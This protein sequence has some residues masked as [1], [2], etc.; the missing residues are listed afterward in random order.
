MFVVAL[1]ES[2]AVIGLVVPGATVMLA[3]G[4]LIALGAMSFWTT[5]LLAVT[6]AIIGD[7]ISFWI[8]R[9]YRD[10]LRG[11]WPFR[12]HPDWLARGEAF[13]QRHGGK[14]VAFGRFVGPV[15]AFVP[16]VAGMLGMPPATF[17]TMNVLSALAWAPAYLLPGMAFGASLALAGVVATRLAALLLLLGVLTWL[18]IWLVRAVYRLLSPRAAVMTQELLTWASRHPLGARVIRGLLDPS[19]PAPR[20]LAVMGAVFLGSAWLFFGVLEDVVTGDPLVRADQAFFNLA[21]SLRTPWGD[22]VMVLV[23]E[24]GDGVVIALV[25]LLV[26]V[27][28]LWQRR[29]RTAGYWVAAIGF[30]QLA[31]TMIK[32]ILQRSRP[33]VDLY[34]NGAS[35]YAF[36]SGHATMS[37]VAYGFLAVLIAGKLPPGRRWAPYAGAALLVA[38][39]AL[40][41]LYLG[42]HWF[43]DVLGGLSLGLAWVCLLGIAYFRH[44]PPG[45]VPRGLPTVALAALVLVG[46]WHVANSYSTDLQRYTPQ[47]TVDHMES[48]SWWSGEWR[49]L[50]AYRQDLEGEL[51]DPLNVQWA[52][53]LDDVRAALEARGWHAPV[54]LTAANALSWLLPD[55]KLDALPMLPHVHEGRNESLL[56]L[57]PPDGHLDRQIVLRLWR[58]AIVLDPAGTP[59]W[60]GSVSIQEPRRILLLTVPVTAHEYDTPLMMLRKS[61]GDLRNNSVDRSPDP[62][63]Q[64]YEWK[65]D[66][67]LVDP[68]S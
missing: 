32:L 67:L 66:V 30:G 8:G 63:R 10:Q 51:E 62:T 60:I 59:L 7:G 45:P 49:E 53:S 33:L 44:A 29:W 40:S 9:R 12:R 25:A 1:S 50:P 14:S 48:A 34:G 24:L 52:G 15:R 17:Y 18:V 11:V 46:G 61:L 58:T 21:Q 54:P 20:T 26:L 3:A 28:L 39:I 37:M 68:S 13:F 19:Q 43:S 6:G 42:A 22:R 64:K 36:P 35:V 65:G 16:I 4:A 5:T 47:P 31:A 57:H 56:L 55:S 27:W 23:T 38:A 2:L 41:R